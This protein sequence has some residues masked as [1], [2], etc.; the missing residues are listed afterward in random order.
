MHGPG[1]TPVDAGPKAGIS[2][3][4]L[5]WH[6]RAQPTI[7]PFGFCR[8]RVSGVIGATATLRTI[9]PLAGSNIPHARHTSRGDDTGETQN[10]LMFRGT[11]RLE[12]E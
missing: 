9:R 12:A 1:Q 6:F 8:R 3:I 2:G 11:L 4:D 10:W 5:S 7:R